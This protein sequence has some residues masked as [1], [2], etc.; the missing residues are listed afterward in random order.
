M[1]SRSSAHRLVFLST[2]VLVLVMMLLS[3][4]CS[5]MWDGDRIYA[6]S[7]PN[8]F[9]HNIGLLDLMVTNLAVFGEHCH[10]LSLK[11]KL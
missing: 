9:R 10:F 1:I 5:A 2:L 3:P 6:I 11:S 4:P 8:L 7:E